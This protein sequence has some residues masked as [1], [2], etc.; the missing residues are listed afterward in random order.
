M[1]L[2]ET[3]VSNLILTIFDTYIV[4]KYMGIFFL[5][6]GNIKVEIFS[7][8]GFLIYTSLVYVFCNIPI[9]LM[10]TTILGYIVLTYNYKAPITKRIFSSV[11]IYIIMVSCELAATV[12][13]IGYNPTSPFT[14]TTFSASFPFLTL[15]RVINYI[16]CVIISQ[17][18][19]LR[20]EVSLPRSFWVNILLIPFISL[21]S[22]L[23]ISTSHVIKSAWALIMSAIL[24]LITNFSVIYLYNSMSATYKEKYNNKLMCRQNEYYG[25]QFETM[26]HSLSVRNAE[27]HDLKNHLSAIETL[28]H[29]NESDKAIEHISKIMNI[30]SSNR[31]YSATGNVVIDSILNYQV[32]EAKLNGIN[33]NLDINVPEYIN[34]SS[35]DMTIILGNII[36][37]AINA[38]KKLTKNKIIDL[39]I[40]YNKGRLLLQ[41][42]IILMVY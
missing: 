27:R 38:T 31:E 18:C 17:Y 37:N 22:F 8:I 40:K 5:K 3:Q 42:I 29:M 30:Y 41:L 25:N 39:I 26:K 10:V 34:I 9:V 35:F 28:I 12:I 24:S 7:Y 13:Y 20:D 33:F 4:Y 1:E 21:I 15:M 23:F 11:L 14:T 16:I 32:H 6:D 19:K 2:S 36:D